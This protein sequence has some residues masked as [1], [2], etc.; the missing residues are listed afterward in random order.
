MNFASIRVVKRR[1]TIGC[2]RQVL[3]YSFQWETHAR[4][5]QAYMDPNTNKLIIRQS[6]LLDVSG[7]HPPPDAYILLRWMMN[8]PTGETEYRGDKAKVEIEAK[9]K[10]K[11]KEES[12]VKEESTAKVEMVSRHK[13]VNKLPVVPL[14]PRWKN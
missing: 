7:E 12:K 13:R 2:Y 3:I 5:T 14:K 6:R 9:V 4:I 1:L 11:A 8:T 10:G